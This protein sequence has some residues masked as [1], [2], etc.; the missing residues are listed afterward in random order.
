MAEE[1]LTSMRRNKNV[2][3]VRRGS[4]LRRLAAVVAFLA[5]GALVIRFEALTAGYVLATLLLSAFFV[6]V[7]FDIGVPKGASTTVE[8]AASEAAFVSEAGEAER[9]PAGD[10]RPDPASRE[11][12]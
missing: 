10:L 11:A 7:A 8:P 9:S 1:D 2:E 5:G 12:A 6:A 4:T 3:D